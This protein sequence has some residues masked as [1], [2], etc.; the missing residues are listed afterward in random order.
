MSSK[1]INQK[2]H[3]PRSKQSIHFYLLCQFR[4]LISDCSREEK[5]IPSILDS[6]SQEATYSRAGD[7]AS[8]KIK[9]NIGS[10]FNKV[11]KLSCHESCDISHNV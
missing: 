5:E 11:A 6:C 4:K 10:L 9:Y 2:L 1:F 7:L 8:N 3:F